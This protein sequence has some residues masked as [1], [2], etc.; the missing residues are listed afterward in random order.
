MFE[1]VFC[2][3]FT[4]RLKIDDFLIVKRLGKSDFLLGGPPYVALTVYYAVSHS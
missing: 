2:L 4:D 1:H 3:R